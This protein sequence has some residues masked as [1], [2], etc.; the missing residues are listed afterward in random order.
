M[1]KR[2]LADAHSEYEQLRRENVATILSYG[3]NFMDMVCRDACDGHDV[4]RVSWIF[5]AVFHY[6]ITSPSSFDKF[7]G[8]LKMFNISFLRI[9]YSY[10]EQ[11]HHCILCFVNNANEWGMVIM[12]DP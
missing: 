2:I 3:D 5:S 8:S 12:P 9:I 7:F 10:R 1:G 11:D 6:A 4:G